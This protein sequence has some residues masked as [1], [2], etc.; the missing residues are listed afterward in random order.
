L[1]KKVFTLNEKKC[2]FFAEA[3]EVLGHNVSENQCAPLDTDVQR[4]NE[5]AI[6]QFFWD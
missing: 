1:T 6:A 4:K 3:I 5:K 2:Q